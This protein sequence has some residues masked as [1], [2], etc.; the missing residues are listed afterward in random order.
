[1]AT[2]TTKNKQRTSSPGGAGDDMLSR[3]PGRG[4]Q[5]PGADAERH[6]RATTGKSKRPGRAR[7]RSKEETDDMPGGMENYAGR[8]ETDSGP[9]APGGMTGYAGTE[10]PREGR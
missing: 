6:L 7:S 3:S 5:T 1:M 9:G 10:P 2:R 4:D 8:G